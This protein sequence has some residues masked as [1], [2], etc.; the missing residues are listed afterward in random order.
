MG[1]RSSIERLPP[2]IKKAVDDAIANKATIEEIVAKLRELGAQASR[3]SVGRY[4]KSVKAVADKIRQS[5]DVA[6]ALV[7]E[8]GPNAAEGKTGR[9]LVQILQTISFKLLMKQAE[10]D[11]PDIDA[12]DLHFLARALKDMSSARQIEINVEA[13]I[14]REFVQKLDAAVAEAE[15]A[16]EKGLSAERVAQLRREFL[17]VRG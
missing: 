9:A 5:Q 2:A 15:K 4:A 7:K 6:E 14:R 1:R 8:I 3:S 13:K 12:K 16:G 17:G 10:G 11:E